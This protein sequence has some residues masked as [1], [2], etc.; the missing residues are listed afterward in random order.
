RE[1]A[2]NVL[3]EISP[4]HVA[5]FLARGLAGAVD[6]DKVGPF[7]GD[8][9]RRAREQ[10]WLEPLLREGVQKLAQWADT[11]ESRE[12]IIRRLRGAAE[13]Y[14]QR[15]WFKRVTFQVAEAFGGVDL[16]HAAG[17]LQAEIRTFAADQ[18][19]EDSQVGQIVRDGLEAIEARLREDPEFLADAR[20]FLL[21]TSSTG[22]LPTL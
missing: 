19:Q 12:V 6:A 3:D 22:T 15:H 16:E 18:L 1:V 7:L 4:Q 5:G 2:R 10:G 17:V 8:L 11:P 13:T 21:E 20:A 14:Q 9:A